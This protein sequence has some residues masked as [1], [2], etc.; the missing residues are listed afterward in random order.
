MTPSLTLHCV[1]DVDHD[2][3]HALWLLKWYVRTELVR[4]YQ[5]V[6]GLETPW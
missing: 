6:G 4:A 3:H 2:A 5:S 1:T